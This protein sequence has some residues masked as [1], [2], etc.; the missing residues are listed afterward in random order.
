MLLLFKV[1]R[2]TKNPKFENLNRLLMIV[3]LF[4]LAMKA[5]YLFIN[6]ICYKQGIPNGIFLFWF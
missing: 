3:H 1:Q 5:S 4:S 6:G 2:C